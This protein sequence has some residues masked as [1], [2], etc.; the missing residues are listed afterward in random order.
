MYL[1]NELIEYDF[2]S[3]KYNHNRQTPGVAGVW[4]GYFIW[5]SIFMLVAKISVSQIYH[6]VTNV[7]T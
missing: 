1:Y 6:A 5:L 3:S 7:E 4:K 2:F